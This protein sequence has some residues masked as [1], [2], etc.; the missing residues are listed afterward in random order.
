MPFSALLFVILATSNAPDTGELPGA[1]LDGDGH[2]DQLTFH[3]AADGTRG[4]LQLVPGAGGS[5]TSPLYPAWKAVTARL[6]RG[7]RDQVVLGT[8]TTKRTRAGEPPRRSIWVVGFDGHRWVERWRG[9]ALA[10]P[11]EDFTVADLDHDGLTE[12]VVRECGGPVE[13]FAA[14]AWQGFGLAGR[15]RVRAPCV[16]GEA[17][18][19]ERLRLEGERLWLDD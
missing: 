10:R 2:A 8:W 7:A 11:F 9:S 18:R 6:E 16:D 5:H 1:D 14:Y 17:P 12:I 4:F 13:G 3:G 15:G 19:W